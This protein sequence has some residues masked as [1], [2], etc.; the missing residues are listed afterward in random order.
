MWMAPDM[1]ELFCVKGRGRLR[2][3]RPHREAARLPVLGSVM[4][5]N[6]D[7]SA[8]YRECRN[9]R[10]TVLICPNL[11]PQPRERAIAALGDPLE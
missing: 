3:V 4:S 6:T 5:S 2:Y 9:E 10:P 11:N 7:I 1:P 8:H